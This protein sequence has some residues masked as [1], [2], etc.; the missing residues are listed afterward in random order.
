[1][2]TLLLIDDEPSI[3]WGLKTLAESIGHSVRTASSAELG[4]REAEKLPRPDVIFLDVR[5]PGMDGLSAMSRLQDLAPDAS[6]IVMTAHGELETAVKAIRQGAFEYLTKPFDLAIAERVMDRAVQRRLSSVE[7]I[8]TAPGPGLQN[9]IVGRS[10]AVQEVFKQIALVAGSEA[11]VL[12]TG[13]SGTG[14]ELVARAIH[15]YSR[16]SD[17]PFVP[18][19]VA[20]LSST[21]AESELFGHVRGA[22]TGADVART[23]LLEQARGGTVFLDE[24]AEIPLPLQVKLL[25][26]LEYGEVFPV[27]SDKPRSIEFRLVSA[28]HQSLRDKVANGSFRHDLFFRLMAFQIDLPALRHR[29]DDLRELAEHFITTMSAKNQL[30]RPTLSKAALSEIVRRPWHG[31]VRELRNAIEHAVIVARGGQIEP[32]HIPIA[33][34]PVGQPSSAAPADLLAPLIQEWAAT[35]LREFMNLEDLYERFLAVVEPPL[36]KAT[37]IHELNQCTSAA[38]KLGLH[39]HTLR[40]KL[41][42]YGI[43]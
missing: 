2:A 25:R 35:Q 20:A 16:R 32:E 26:A 39:R 40:K 11:C 41:D 7:Q 29:G 38:K 13:E 43:E 37:L 17:G 19:H 31:N 14:K 1:M 18:V 28:T 3:C 12:I 8:S 6:I 24:V 27:G 36:L 42:Q 5:L 33:A 30:V 15:R 34:P 21:L 23:G 10:P 9:P 22:F 4:F